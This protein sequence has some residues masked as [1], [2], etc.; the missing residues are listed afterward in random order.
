L[1]VRIT[2]SAP[3]LIVFDNID[4][5]VD[6]EQLKLVGA[7]G[8]FLEHF[9][10]LDTAS[11]LV[12]TCRPPIK[13]QSTHLLSHNLLGL[14]SDAAIR[15]FE[16]RR[17]GSDRDA[18]GRAHVATRGHAFWLDLLAAQVARRA[19]S[20]NL[21]DL[22]HS[23]SEGSGEIPDATLRSIWNSL[24]QREQVVLQALTEALRPATILELA[25]YVRHEINFN[26]LGKAVSLLRDLNLIVV[27]V[28]ANESD[29]FELHPLI[30]AFIQKT[31]SRSERVPY[32]MAILSNYIAWLKPFVADISA[33]RS[34]EAV[35][36]S[37]EAAELC[38][39][40]DRHED[41]LDW[42]HKVAAAVRWREPP[43]E[44]VRIAQ[45]LFANAGVQK[46][47]KHPQFDI[48]YGGYLE[49]LSN[50]GKTEAAIDAL[51]AYATTLEGKM[52][53]TSIIAICNATSTGST[54]S[55]Q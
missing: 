47:K 18:I 51:T 20:I 53:A 3:V 16:L 36:R 28:G 33:E 40:A 34:T 11:R 10:N 6:L 21:D 48:V 39:N 23:I 29:A 38:I 12:F 27:K 15:L 19:P 52:H 30:R 25:E 44:F 31:I 22:L 1:F 41:A 2:A 8:E 9:L 49:I 50:L 55:I 26:A 54:G 46:L 5:Y 43:G 14:D 7:A 35:H 42:L 45:R 17:A 4:H 24:R 37:I 32:I 13:S